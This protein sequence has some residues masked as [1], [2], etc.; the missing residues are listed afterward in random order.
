VVGIDPGR[1]A[2]EVVRTAAAEAERRGTQLAIVAVARRSGDIGH[3]VEGWRADDGWTESAARRALADAFEGLGTVTS[4]V[5]TTTTCLSEDEVTPERHPLSCAEILV[6]GSRG[7]HGRLAFGLTSVSRVLLKAAHCPVLTV[8]PDTGPAA[9]RPTARSS[10]AWATTRGTAT[11]CSPRSPRRRTGTRACTCSTP[12]SHASTTPCRGLSRAEAAVATVT[13]GIDPGPGTSVSVLLT[14]DAP[15]VAL[16]REAEHASL[17]VIGSRP[18]ALSGLVLDTVSRAVLDAARCPVLVV[19][20]GEPATGAPAARGH[21]RVGTK[22]PL[23]A[24]VGPCPRTAA[25]REC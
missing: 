9:R 12:T 7:R 19:Q 22:D 2:E 1:R 13:E 17:V 4:R 24:A 20:R 5:P 18:G 25:R 14:Q 15:A 21:P 16:L 8:P 3:S 11:S 6:V 10:W 23:I